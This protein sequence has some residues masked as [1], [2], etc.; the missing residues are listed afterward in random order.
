MKI[1]FVFIALFFLLSCSDNNTSISKE[2]TIKTASIMQTDGYELMQQKCFICHFEKPDPAKKNQMIAP[3][4]LRVQE[5][6]KST[7][8]QKAEFMAAAMAYIKNPSKEKTLMP[9]AVK[10]FNLMPA[11]VYENQDLEL[12]VEVLYD[13]DFGAAV[14]MKNYKKAGLKLNNGEKWQL[15]PE[16]I[17]MINAI[18]DKINNFNSDNITEY[19]QLGR[20][21]FDKTKVIMLDDAY[22]GSIFDQ[23]HIFFAGIENNMHTLMSAKSIDEA[24]NELAELKIKFNE[25]NHYFK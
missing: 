2:T 21:I 18:S 13:L 22:N 20:E 14:Q 3:P 16:S 8:P 9:G 4:M 10:K 11:L 1:N 25:F 12:I 7:Y 19:N 23:I 15:K 24:K 17:Q 6:Y 5:H